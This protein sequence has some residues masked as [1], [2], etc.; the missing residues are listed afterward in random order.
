MPVTFDPAV[1]TQKLRDHL[2]SHDKPIA[3]LF[4][5]GTSAAVAGT[6]GKPLVP[7]VAVLTERVADAVRAKSPRFKAA[8]DAIVAALPADQ[9]TIEDVLSAVRRMCAAVIGSDKLAGLNAAQLTE[10]EQTI[11]HTIA[12]EVRPEAARF[13]DTLPHQSLGRWLGRIDRPTPVEIFTTNYDTLIERALE[14]EW[15][16]LFDGFV[17]AREPFFSPASLAREPMAPGR[18]WTRLWK[19]HG[20]VNWSARS[21]P[22]LGDRIVRGPENDVGEMILPSQLKYD[23][24]RKQ[25]YLAMID[26]FRRVLTEREDAVLVTAGYSFG[27]QHLNEVI[28]EALDANPRLHVFALC[29][30][31]PEPDSELG[32]EARRRN[33]IIVLGPKEAIV[34]GRVGSWLLRDPGRSVGRVADIFDIKPM[35][36]TASGGTA[37]GGATATGTLVLGDFNK[38]CVL[39]DQIVGSD[40]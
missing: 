37:A 4:G 1:E 39:L 8:W 17:G 10:L 15:V 22:S 19:V 13:P 36:G 25:P 7:T 11:Q 5:A 32:R 2:A 35:G 23:E 31:D 38:L 29:F 14:T 6:D 33:N 3:F 20:S 30:E 28:L 24:S 12:R 27:D 18:R 9:R 26:R 16:P 21:G 40:A 34:G